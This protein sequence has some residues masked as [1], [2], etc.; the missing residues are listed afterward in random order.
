MKSTPFSLTVF[1]L[2]ALQGCDQLPGT[3]RYDIASD[4]AGRT[5]RID[6]RTGEITIID[7]D[8]LITPKRAEEVEKVRKDDESKLADAKSY[9]DRPIKHLFIAGSLSTSW[10][11]GRIYYSVRLY[12]INQEDA[13]GKS[14]S[15][16][17]AN[18]NLPIFKNNM[19]R[20][21]F[22][23]ILEDVPFELLRAKL[24]TT[25]IADDK[26]DLQGYIAKGNAPMSQEAYKRL[27]NW[28]VSWQQRGR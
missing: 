6:K 15:E 22:T 13:T 27:D 12:P 23:L 20:H 21:D 3:S 2:L 26:G 24:D 7:G 8:R 28:N 1:F 16:K 19:L 4:K 9:A 17:V 25:Y 5:V 18:P 11:N 10:Q 14:R